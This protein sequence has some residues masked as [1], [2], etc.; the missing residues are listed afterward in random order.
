MRLAKAYSAERL[1]AA[2]ERALLLQ[3]CSYRSLKSIL[4]RSL[5]RQIGLEPPT[6]KPGPQEGNIRGG[7]YYCQT[8]PLIQ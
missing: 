5:P 4:S 1:E 6:E 2:S 3:A 7:E 8:G